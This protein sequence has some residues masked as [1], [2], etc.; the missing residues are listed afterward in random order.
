MKPYS[1]IKIGDVYKNPI[2]FTEWYVIDKDD[3]EKLIKI[4]MLSFDGNFNNTEIW[5][6]TS[7]RVFGFP[8][9]L[10]GY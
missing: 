3:S 2:T 5:K 6:K 1:R 10:E 4:A 7:D 8:C 9:V